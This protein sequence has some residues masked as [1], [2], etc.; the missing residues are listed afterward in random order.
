MEIVMRFQ[1]TARRLSV[2]ARPRYKQ[3]SRA[4]ALD[5]VVQTKCRASGLDEQ[6][7]AFVLG[8]L[9]VA[10]P[11]WGAVTRQRVAAGQGV[12]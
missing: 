4:S 11:R 8:S 2:E 1:S 3:K 9:A 7:E 10:M 12:A 6:G 5:V